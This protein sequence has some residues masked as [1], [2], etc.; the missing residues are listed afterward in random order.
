MKNM[1]LLFIFGTCLI[2][3]ACA[4][5]RQAY[6][7]DGKKGY[8]IDCSGSALNWG[9]CY[10]EA[11]RLC[12]EKGYD[13]LA[14][15]GDRNSTV[16]GSSQFFGGGTFNSRSMLVVCKGEPSDTQTK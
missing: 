13:V 7:P 6:T 16:A 8:T 5:S 9:M 10:E 4:T 12:K 1:Q 15:E 11:G 3:S 14:K 2:A